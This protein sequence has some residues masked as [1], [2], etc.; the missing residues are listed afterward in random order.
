MNDFLDYMQLDPIFRSHHHGELTFSMIYAYSED[1]ILT[2]SHDEVVH[3]KCSLISKMPPPYENQ[4][5]GLRALY[6]T[7]PHTRARRC[8]SWAVSLHNS[9]NGRTSAD[10]T[11]CC[12]IIRRTARCR[13][14]S[15]RSITSTLLLRS[16]GSR[17]PT[18]AA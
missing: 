4:F 9:P 8:C 3:G 5:G 18:G 6:G 10:W 2:L 7:W 16:C 12:W 13:R 15:R 11:G 17:I 1:F 14:T